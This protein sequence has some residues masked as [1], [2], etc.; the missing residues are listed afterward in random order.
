M[1][2]N[3]EVITT[4]KRLLLW[5]PSVLIEYTR[6]IQILKASS[7]SGTVTSSSILPFAQ[8]HGYPKI[9]FLSGHANFSLFV[10]VC[11]FEKS[12][13]HSVRGLFFLSFP[14]MS[15]EL[16]RFE[17][18][19][20]YFPK[21]FVVLWFLFFRQ[22]ASLFPFFNLPV[23]PA[24]LLGFHISLQSLLIPFLNVFLSRIGLLTT[25]GAG[26]VCLCVFT[27][28]WY[29]LCFHFA[30][31]DST[32]SW[33]VGEWALQ[34]RLQVFLLYPFEKVVE[35]RYLRGLWNA[36]RLNVNPGWNMMQYA[37]LEPFSCAVIQGDLQ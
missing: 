18:K 14:M 23:H 32:M 29:L 25:V 30:G 10:S 11:I 36:R 16:R 9:N 21:T 35:V 24:W 22:K 34:R 27:I 37:T 33:A 26:C 13:S 19:C 12:V 1:E 28:L 20:V 4:S 2:W 5:S 6:T 7:L 31:F 8:I 15:W 17:L 3:W